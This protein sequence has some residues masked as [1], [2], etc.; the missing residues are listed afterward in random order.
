MA[1]KPSSGVQRG[2]G[3]ANDRSPFGVVG[4]PLPVDDDARLVADGPRVVPGRHDREVAWAVLHLFAVVHHDLHPPGHEVA[5]VGGLAAVGLG[6]RLD[7][8]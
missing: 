5:H 7:V 1:R 2:F 4:E 8:L 6:D 3:R